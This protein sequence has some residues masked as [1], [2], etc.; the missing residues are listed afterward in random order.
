M[1]YEQRT[2]YVCALKL[3]KALIREGERVQ[4]TCE[5]KCDPKVKE[6]CTH[7]AVLGFCTPE[8]QKKILDDEAHKREEAEKAAKKKKPSA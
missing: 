4:H 3:C 6:I 7:V 2:R 5:W 1:C 8:C